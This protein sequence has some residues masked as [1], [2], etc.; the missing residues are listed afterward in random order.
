MNKKSILTKGGK[1]MLSNKDEKAIEQ[2]MQEMWDKGL[3]HLFPLDD[4]TNEKYSSAY[5]YEFEESVE[6]LIGCIN[7]HINH[8]MYFSRQIFA[9]WVM[10][11]VIDSIFEDDYNCNSFKFFDVICVVYDKLRYI[12]VPHF[13]WYNREDKF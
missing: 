1:Q 6:E 11:N 12:I 8:K 5:K 2:I 7:S 4:D 3:E 9:S 10:I 13:D